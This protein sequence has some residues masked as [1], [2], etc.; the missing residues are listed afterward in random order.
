MVQAYGPTGLNKPDKAVGGAWRSSSTRASRRRRPLY[1]QLAM[2]AYGAGQTRKGDLAADKAVELARQGPSASRSSDADRARQG[3]R[4][5]GAGAGATG[6]RRA[7]PT[8]AGS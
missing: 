2:L 4:L 5:A 8:T 1:A 3:R 7:E 6:S